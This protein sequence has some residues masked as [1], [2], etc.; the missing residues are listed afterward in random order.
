[1]PLIVHYYFAYGSNMDTNRVE[2][3]GL[4]YTEVVG[5]CLNGFKL[6]FNKRSRLKPVSGRANLQQCSKSSACGVLYKLQD[7]SDVV[8]MDS[9]EHA[10]V[11]YRRL[12]VE[13]HT[14]HQPVAAW[15]YFATPRATDN[16][17]KPQ[18][19]YLNHL[20]AG[21]DFLPNEY[22]AMLE[23]VDCVD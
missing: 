18:R 13:V 2:E 15:T 10:P 14:A 6:R 9:F 3:R 4:G 23:N 8:V 5:G 21:R 12:I 22:V 1:M 16:S 7:P 17:L 19:S 11:D 20:L